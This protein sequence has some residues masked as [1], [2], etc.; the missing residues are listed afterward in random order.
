MCSCENLLNFSYQIHITWRTFE[1]WIQFHF[2]IFSF[3]KWRELVSPFSTWKLEWI[4]FIDSTSRLLLT[5]IW[6][7]NHLLDWGGKSFNSQ[8]NLKRSVTPG[9]MG[10]TPTHTNTGKS[11]WIGYQ[12]SCWLPKDWQVSHLSWISKNSKMR[13]SS[14]ALKPRADFSRSSNRG[15]SGPVKWQTSKRFEETPRFPLKATGGS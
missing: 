12:V 3:K 11:M 9:S 4:C 15:T 6:F 5:Q 2:G 10:S 7:R 8:V 13:G 14:L 1:M